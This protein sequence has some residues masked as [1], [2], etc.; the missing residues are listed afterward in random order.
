[1]LGGPLRRLVGGRQVTMEADA[2]RGLLGALAARGGPDLARML[3]AD[4]DAPGGEANADLR[5]LVNGRDV[6][7][8]D[9]LAT[10]LTPDDTVTLHMT[11]ARGYPGG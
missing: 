10:R 1:M 8:L 6:T 5:V 4:P 11:G 9:G 2:V 7:F 3:F